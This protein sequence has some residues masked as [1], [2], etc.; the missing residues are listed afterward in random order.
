MK[1]LKATKK[2]KRTRRKEKR[3]KMETLNIVGHNT[4]NENIPTPEIA[5]LK[6]LEKESFK[7]DICVLVVMVLYLIF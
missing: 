1:L 7:G 3:K 6:L 2:K 4:K 5:T